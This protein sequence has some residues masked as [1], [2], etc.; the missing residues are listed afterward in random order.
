[1]RLISLG[2]EN[3]RQHKSTEI[4]FP[5]GLT[6]ILGSNG[7]G[8]STI[9]EAI[10]WALYGNQSG[11]TRG[12]ADTLIW[13][14]APGKSS[15]IA[16]LT[17]AFNGQTYT[18][19]RSQS[20]SK[21]TA[22]LRHDGK[23][24][25]N[26]TK[27]VNERLSQILGMTHQEFFNSYF[28]GQKDLNFL[29]AIK[30]ATERERFIAKMLGYERLSEVQ[31][32]AGKTG[33]LRDRRR[34]QERQVD[35]LAGS[36]GDIE[37]I[38][39]QIER[40]QSALTELQMQLANA[41][42][43]L[44]AAMD[45][46]QALEPKIDELEVDR[47]R[48][49][50]LNSQRQVQQANL[51]QVNRQILQLTQ[52]RDR[53]STD[54]DRYTA[55]SLEVVDYEQMQAQV[56][57]L[58]EQKQ[59]AIERNELQARVVKLELE[60][61][62]LQQQL[63]KLEHVASSLQQSQEAIANYQSQQQANASEIQAQT[64]LWQ[65]QQAD[66]KA[67]IKTE[68]Q[69]LKQIETQKRAI[70]TAG[71]AGICPTCER[72]LNEEYDTVIDRFTAQIAH[73]QLHVSDWQSRLDGLN[74]PPIQLA[75]LQSSQAQ[76]GQIVSQE[77]KREQKLSIDL[78]KRQLLN[79]NLTAKQIE[80]DRLTTAIDRIHPNFDPALYERLIAELRLLKPKHEDWLRMADVPQRLS[81]I[82]IQLAN[83]QQEQTQILKAIAQIDR[84][85][86]VL[87]FTEAEYQQLKVAIAHATDHME[88]AR[89]IYVEVQQ[90]VALA[91]RDLETSRQQ[92]IE[93]HRKDKEYKAA[94]QELA[95]LDELDLAFTEMRQHLTEQI[96][97]Q[98][99]DSASIFLNQLTDGRYNAIEIDSKYNV[100]VLDDGDRKPAISGG[101]E[102]IVN[103]CLR[104]AISQMITE[105]SG[106]PFS[107]LVLDEVF[108]SLDRGRQ[109]NV[110]GLLHALEEHFE[111][112]LII[113]HIEA[114]QESL[115]HTI[116]LE[117][118]PQQKCS[119]LAI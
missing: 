113:T 9:L 37:A 48:F 11:V 39:T 41:N 55:L 61:S 4:H 67:R 69:S 38:A 36:R 65:E 46:K 78:A 83:Q 73:L 80:C 62:D 31:G 81:Q 115:N 77:Q 22:E 40:Q 29:G 63:A 14:L 90:Q 17:F 43:I 104:L 66:L 5:N 18:V 82:D 44:I 28:T 84:E 118:D 23:T 21:S 24:I 8:K 1:M 7:S 103:L 114:T 50:Q 20:T 2:L 33:T 112:V 101:E 26:S 64:L 108:G 47:D 32:A 95:L 109:D 92:E 86:V 60:I 19:K 35:L 93:F 54:A 70:S 111:Q 105:R 25:A 58:S 76:L 34:Q 97:P 27:A 15:A 91:S 102:D 53:L 116:R 74:T 49:N 16:E 51:A 56:T 119:R 107:L 85:L 42:V 72:A 52:E 79:E 57:N 71:H 96:R 89:H 99:A 117:F 68:Q 87:N 59:F 100:V 106:Q 75:Q 3:F 94:K 12:E 30:G 88:S 110:L 98:L 10:A 13:R 6:G 45:R